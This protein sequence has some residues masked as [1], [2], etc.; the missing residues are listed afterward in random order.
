MTARVHKK[1]GAVHMKMM[2]IAWL[3]AVALAVCLWARGRHEGFD[4]KIVGGQRADYERY[5]YFVKLIFE[6]NDGGARFKGRLCGGALVA[7]D[8]VLTAAHCVLNPAAHKFLYAVIGGN[9]T[10]RIRNVAISKQSDLAMLTLSSP[11]T[12]Q[13]I[14]IRTRDLPTRSVVRALG[15]GVKNP[16]GTQPGANSQAF[17]YLNLTYVDN[18]TAAA[19]LRQEAALTDG[20][21]DTFVAILEDPQTP[22]AF[23]IG[24]PGKT[25]C[26]GDSGG[27]L[28]VDSGRLGPR[29]DELVGVL[30]TLLFSKKA[31]SLGWL[32]DPSMQRSYIGYTAARGSSEFSAAPV[33]APK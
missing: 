25:V 23:V 30:S 11:S 13:P 15:T 32:C 17:E 28:I 18:K 1:I 31:L 7:P 16:D 24:P 26:Q 29:K 33:A 3:V 27:P 10:R 21:R 12:K 2:L 4:P 19:Y 20:V 9:E 8:K 6:G 22:S 14:K 5:P